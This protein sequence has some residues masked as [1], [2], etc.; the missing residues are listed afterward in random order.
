MARALALAEAG[1]G[2]VWPNPA[3]GCVLVQG[4][5]VV[6]EGATRPGGR[7]HAETEA[8]AAAGAAARGATAYVTL[9]PCAHHGRTPPCAD[10]LVAAGI[11]RCVVATGD[12]DAR[13]AGRGLAILR[14]AGI[15]VETG[16]AEAAARALNEGYFLNRQQGRPWVTL[17]LAVSLDGRIAL[18]SG[19][20]R[21]IT[22]PE[23][24]CQV[25]ALRAS[26]DAVMIGA[27][28]ARA[29]DPMLD[30]REGI[31][32]PRP[33]VRIVIDPRLS[34]RADSRLAASAAD[35]PLWLL[36]GPLG[37]PPALPGARLFELPPGRGGIDLA[38]AMARLGGEGLTRILCEGGGTLAVG[39]VAAGLVDELILMTAGKVI[40]GDGL[41]AFA[42][43][44]LTSL[45]DAPRFTL[46][47]HKALGGDLMSR[48]RRA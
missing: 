33:P 20:S 6:G 2:T 3:V 42:A 22:G 47:E 39:L 35:Q 7:P 24:R 45:D 14:D 5:Q 41:P 19:V 15:A 46:A 32:T 34:L 44:G 29:D 31:E 17:K 11:R 13:V 23:A 43:L 38:A 4:E 25:H 28:T 9:E 26:H 1:L 12:P 48:W 8:L 18:G 27:G 36:H 30:V 16:V 37:D 10:A 40:G 21:W